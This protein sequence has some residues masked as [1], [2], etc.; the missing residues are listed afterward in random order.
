LID[1]VPESRGGRECTA[2]ESRARKRGDELSAS[3]YSQRMSYLS[4]PSSR[5]IGGVLMLTAIVLGENLAVAEGCF[6]RLSDQAPCS[7]A[8]ITNR[9]RL[10][11]PP[12]RGSVG[13]Q[14]RPL[15]ARV[16]NP[17][18]KT[19]PGQRGEWTG[20]VAGF[21]RAALYLQI[22]KRAELLDEFRIGE[23]DLAGT[24]TPFTFRAQ[25]PEVVGWE[26]RITTKAY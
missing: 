17:Q 21:G 9:P 1:P 22:T 26:W 4:Q 18:L 6:G 14:A 10:A 11:P 25:L 13:S 20:I 3:L 7:A 5:V 2:L 24:P 15:N 16:V 12:M 19:L 8:S 23:V